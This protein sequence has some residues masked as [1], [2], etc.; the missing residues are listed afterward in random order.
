MRPFNKREQRVIDIIANLGIEN[1][2]TFSKILQE[3]YFTEES[4]RI[5]I[6]NHVTKDVLLY[7]SVEKFDNITQRAKAIGEF[8]ELVSLISYLINERFLTIL[9]IKSNSKM[10]FMYQGFSAG[11]QSTSTSIS[12]QEKDGTSSLIM[13]DKITK[14]DGSISFKSLSFKDLYEPICKNLTG[15]IYPTEGLVFL[16]SHKFKTEEDIKFRKQYFISWVSI[17][18]AF[19]IGLISIVLSID[20]SQSSSEAT[21]NQTKIIENFKIDQMKISLEELQT[22]KNIESNTEH[23]LK[24]D[25]VLRLKNN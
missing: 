11:I 2:D 14:S 25:S 15:V 10:D 23:I 7:L 22:I 18:I 4:G 13:S 1:T 17:G 16:A 3:K 5:L 20:S 9:D 12:F 21:Q 8:W 19:L 6:I 24:N